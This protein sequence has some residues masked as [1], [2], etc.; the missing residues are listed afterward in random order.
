[1]GERRLRCDPGSARGGGE[2]FVGEIKRHVR[3][4][5][6]AGARVHAVRAGARDWIAG[7][8]FGRRFRV[9]FWRRRWRLSWLAPYGG[10][11]PLFIA[12][13]AVFHWNVQKLTIVNR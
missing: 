8:V 4:L 2:F 5:P 6:P 7:A 12:F 3:I 9:S 1:L 13:L 10:L 11:R